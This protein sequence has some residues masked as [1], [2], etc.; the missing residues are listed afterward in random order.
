MVV[1]VVGWGGVGDDDA[2]EWSGA[3][4]GAGLRSQH[5]VMRVLVLVVME[6]VVPKVMV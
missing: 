3:L 6:V 1:E 2:S 4:F 5:G